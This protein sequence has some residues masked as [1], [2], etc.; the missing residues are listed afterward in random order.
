MTDKAIHDECY[1]CAFKRTVPGNSHI[2]CTTPD[3]MMMGGDHGIASGWFLYPV[4]FDPVWKTV[5]CANWKE[6]LTK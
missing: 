3:D 1:S 6:R 5:A 4:L 2:R